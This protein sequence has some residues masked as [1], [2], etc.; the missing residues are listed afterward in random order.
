MD[1]AARLREE[2]VATNERRLLVLAGDP[3]QTRKR[4]E[5]ALGAASVDA[6]YVGSASMPY[7]A[8][9][10]K[11][12][13]TLLGTTHDALILDCHEACEP[14]AIGR[15]V[16]AVDGGGLL[17]FLTPP[18]DTWS[19]RR[20]RF[21]ESLAVPPFDVD[22]VSGYFRR[23]LVRTLR[24]HR[25]IAIVDVDTDT[26]EQ[27]GLTD[28][29]P[30]LPEP[31]PTPPATPHFPL[32]AYDSCLTQDQADA[33][34]DF[35]RLREPG[36]AVV[37]EADRGR[38]KSSAAGLAA[39]SLVAE[40]M[41]VLVTAPSIRN[42]REL[43]ARAVELLEGCGKLQSHTHNPE[44]LETESGRIRFLP[45]TDAARL[46]GDPDQMIVDEAASLSVSLLEA[47]LA[48]DSV[49]Y[50]TTVHGYEGTGRGFSVRFRDRLDESPLTVTTVTLDDPIRYAP[51]DP[52]EVWSFRAL[53]LGARPAVE[54]LV[55]DATPDTV[56]YRELS[57]TE[58]CDDEQLLGEVFGLLVLAHYRTEPNDLARLLDAPNVSVHALFHDGHV[59]SVALLAREGSLPADLRA[60]IYEGERIRGNLLPDVLTSQLRDER[61][62]ETV[63][64][65]VMRIAT[66]D[67]VR[68]RGLGSMLLGKIRDTCS[69]D[70][71]G[72]GYGATPELIQFWRENGFETVHLS[73]TRNDRSG[74]HSVLMLDALSSAGEELHSRHTN[75]FLRRTPSMLADPLS[76]LDPAIVRAACR[77]AGG[78]VRLDLTA[79][80]WRVAA[81]LPHGA[82][83]YDTA[84][85][86]IRRL[87][88]R[89]LVDPADDVLSA[90]QERF[91]LRKALQG[92][93]WS[94]V[95][96]EFAFQSEAECKR[97]LGRAVEPLV[98]LYGT[99]TALEERGRFQ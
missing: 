71:L 16:G 7:D 81:G 10:P 70:W 2:A 89:H 72:V 40:G 82:A 54:P 9:A 90:K 68:S 35:E 86:P 20:D 4:V 13:E 26:I 44:V 30:R 17:I 22:D 11:R 42:T 87:F 66:H 41:D 31:A 69:S 76:E 92:A 85:R 67:A 75:W 97:A 61:A 3:E 96:D 80:E 79:M 77:A 21:D 62:G 57:P 88:F 52:V 78:T 12:V 58:L 95:T 98:E 1:I 64:H 94:T 19:T 15:V 37:V 5:D 56:S 73:T 29:P 14:N 45:P 38:G 33:L 28:P 47:F 49:A 53:A 6:T 55:T 8:V 27:D 36:Q 65:R 83:I 60:N 59:V 84:P 91:L 34:A 25:G 32:A 63:G 99:E 18:L 39:A 51:A 93:P 74:E 46:P 43:F 50:T 48:A 23:R 24:T